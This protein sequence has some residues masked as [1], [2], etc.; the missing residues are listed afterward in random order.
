MRSTDAPKYATFEPIRGGGSP[1]KA[2][3]FFSRFV[4]AWAKSLLT[5][6]NQ[7]Q[8]TPNDMWHLSAAN[9]VQPLTQHFQSVYERKGR[10]VL[11]SF[12][13]IY[14]GRFLLIGVLQLL[15]VVGDLYGPGYVLGQI[16]AAVEAPT[17]DTKYV[18]QLVGSLYAVQLM[19]AL[20]KNHLNYVN[21]MV[22]VQFS[23][24]LRSMLFEKALRLDA[25][26]KKDAVAG[27]F[28][29]LFSVDTI[30]VM[31]FATS[32]H[33]MWILPLQ[34]GAVLY[35]LYTIIGWAIFVG[36]SAVLVILL[37]NAIVAILMGAEQELCFKLK[38]DRMK[39]VNEVFGAIQTIKLN[40]WEEKFQAKIRQLRTAELEST[41]SLMRTILVLVT[42]MNCT[43][44]LV[45]VAVFATF[46]L[47]MQ[48]ALTV[49]IVFSTLALFK[50]LQDALVNLPIVIMAL[51]QSLVSAQRITDILHLSEV[52]SK[53]VWTPEHPIAATYAKEEV[54]VA[55][56]N[57]TFGWENERPLFSHINLKV[58][59]GDLVVIHGAEGQGKSSLCSILLGEMHKTGGSVFVGGQVAYFAQQPW[60]Q[61]TTIRENI[62][63]GK[64]YDRILYRKVLD[65][66]ALTSDMAALPAGDRTEI[67]PKGLHLSGSQ[68]ARISLARACYSD[69]DIFLLDSPLLAMNGVAASEVFA[70][71]VLGLLSQKT[72]LL[73]TQDPEVIESKAV[74]R[75]L[76]VQDGKI[77]ESTLDSPRTLQEMPV[78]PLKARAPYWAEATSEL[79]TPTSPS[80]S[81][82]SL[83][84]ML[85]TPPA[86]GGSKASYDD[87]ERLAL[88][89]EARAS[90]AV[91]SGYVAAIGGCPVVFAILLLTTGMQVLKIGGDLWLTRWS[92]GA[93]SEAPDAF[94]AAALQNMGIY[95]ALALGSCFMIALQTYSVLSFGLRGSQRMFDAMLKSL[96]AAP[97]SFFAAT[98]VGNI[99]SCFGD[100]VVACDF[101]IPF[102]LGP[103]LF[104]TSSA[105]FTIGTAVVLTQRVGLLV[106]PLLY[107][108]YCL[109]A[110]AL[111]PLREVTRI[112]TT[113][114]TPLIRLVTEGF[115][116]ASTIRAFG[117]KQ[118]RHFA[119]LNALKIEAFCEARVAHAAINAWFS[120]RMQA[121]SSTIVAVI[122]IALVVLH[123]E[124]SPG[125]VG[126][127]VTY[128]LAVPANLS[129]LVHMWSQL[130]TSMVSPERIQEF[131][132]LDS[133]GARLSPVALPAGW[134]AAGKIEF[135]GVCLRYKPDD[136]LALKNVSFA[137]AGSEKIGIVGHAGAG[138][139]SL[140]MALFR[141]SD[142]VAG[143]VAIDG[144]D[145]AT[146][147]LKTLR[148]RLA[149]VPQN[150]VL[151]KGTLR[152]YLDPF[153]EYSD[154]Q[155]WTALAKVRMTDRIAGDE[156][157]L[158]GVVNENGDNFSVGERQ[159]LCMAQALLRQ[160][161]I[162]VV[163]EVMDPDTDKM[164]QRV[165]SAEL[166]AST[167]LRVTHRLDSLLDYDRILVLEGG[168][169]AQWGRPKTLVRERAGIFYDLAMEG[170][171]LESVI[172]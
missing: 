165:I 171:Y 163:D 73:V 78:T 7:R 36:L 60:I 145:I 106:L 114:L 68:K 93:E 169:V 12:F 120:L 172:L 115:E 88:E 153:E 41:W 118:L 28:A 94:A 128:G 151:F 37:V 10:T 122:L 144:V 117:T 72:V 129:Y 90:P 131:I 150:P 48:Q 69:A 158:L 81:S 25:S 77:I 104:E 159:L 26:S 105:C 42:F 18:L 124:L 111:K 55:I 32:I 34:I 58:K 108:C 97:L 154:E 103:I 39:V 130:E 101:S 30:N 17:L 57:G 35:L 92:N 59:K 63:F 142:V 91:V 148:S 119:C 1:V 127:L 139:S 121:L 14:W 170:G 135:A 22:G 43:P 15:T 29:S 47:W 133:E 89:I 125:L 79:L 143:K 49:A 100:D 76:L 2:A 167:V 21:D 44:I 4:F 147:G 23:S 71:C 132:Q 102:T 50:S 138:K 80:P 5:Q 155:L 62:L 137:A 3:G 85:F 152:S 95:A 113:T 141:L 161:K 67:G 166:A 54:V 156:N 123:D 83:H 140:I 107:M 9:K 162:V 64:S 51:V 20:L 27:D 134:P 66:C 61:N 98:P 19:N 86:T 65:A 11:S 45:T 164:L 53:S 168:E 8:L 110:F 160:A 33:S 84:E 146:I 87:S 16:V 82:F 38:D 74:Q 56:D 13:A 109:G 157:K 99:L 112:E 149:I 96:L 31:P 52:H 136:P 46:T 126:L 116:G 24:S 75:T 70:K 40:A 6:G